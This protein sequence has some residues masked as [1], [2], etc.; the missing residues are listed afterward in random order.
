MHMLIY[1]TNTH[2]DTCTKK[3]KKGKNDVITQTSFKART[4]VF[5]VCLSVYPLSTYLCVNAIFVCV[6]VCTGVHA[7]V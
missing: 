5:I 3:E 6:P 2:R 4:L 1:N 7:H